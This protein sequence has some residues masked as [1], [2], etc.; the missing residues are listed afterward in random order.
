MNISWLGL[1][2]GLILLGLAALLTAVTSA[3]LYLLQSAQLKSKHPGVL[4]FR[5]PSLDFL[6]RVHFAALTWGTLLFTL[7]ILSGVLWARSLSQLGEMLNDKKAILSS[8]ACLLYWGILGLRLSSLRRGHKIAVGTL[9]V[10]VLLF[11]AI[12][13]SHSISRYP[14]KL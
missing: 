3:M 9:L 14:G 11:V 8:A 10:F 6:D 13:S 1:H 4:F 12:L 2:L 7:G 5:L